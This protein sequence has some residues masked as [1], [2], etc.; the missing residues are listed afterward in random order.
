MMLPVDIRWRCFREMLCV[1]FGLGVLLLAGC[2]VLGGIQ[3]SGAQAV[4]GASDDALEGGYAR[5]RARLSG[6][7][8]DRVPCQWGQAV[9]GVLT[10]LD[11]DHNVMALTFDACGG[12]LSSG[13]DAELIRFLEEEQVAATLFMNARWMLA[14]PDAFRALAAEPLFEIANHGLLHRP[15][16]V[17]GRWAYGIQGPSTVADLVD[18]IEL[19]GRMIT[20]LTGSRPVFY[21]P[22]TAY[23]DDI[24][25]QVARSLGYVVAGFSVLGDAGATYTREQVRDALLAAPPG[26]IVILH[27]NHPEGQTRHGVMEAVPLLKKRGVRFV[28]LSEGV[29]LAR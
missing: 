11:T 17:T 15:C 25:V 9:D 19:S 8:Q 29:D 28:T 24:G 5:M 12:P 16:S 26:A 7:F 22:G 18:E 13:Y 6:E 3:R 1:A 20:A 10:R 2:T 14:N 27:M 21:R 4:P 23:C